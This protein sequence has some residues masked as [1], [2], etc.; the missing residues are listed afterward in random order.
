MKGIAFLGALAFALSL[1]HAPILAEPAALNLT[2]TVKTGVLFG[3][4]TTD[5]GAVFKNVPIAQAPMGNLRW[6]EPLPSQSWSGVRDASS[7][8]PVGI[9]A[10][11]LN[12]RR[13]EDC[14]QL[15][16]WTPKWPMH[17]H[18][19]VKVWIH[20]GGNFAGSG[21]ESLFNGDN[22][23]KW[24]KFEAKTRPYLDFMDTGPLPN[25]DCSARPVTCTW[26]IR[27]A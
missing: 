9:Q 6:R 1:G 27:N 3:S 8:G 14:L 13:S 11:N 26:K 21:V 12:T 25:K 5:G 22:L 23:T 7:Y 18:V 16:V 17:S 24:P 10:G 19:Q 4:L 15:N 2:V 20:G